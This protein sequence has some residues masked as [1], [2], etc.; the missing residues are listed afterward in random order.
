MLQEYSRRG[1]PG[2]HLSAEVIHVLTRAITTGQNSYRL[3]WDAP[4]GHWLLDN[5]MTEVDLTPR[6]ETPSKPHA[7]R[8]DKVSSRAYIVACESSMYAFKG[9]G[10]NTRQHFES[11]FR[12]VLFRFI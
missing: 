1:R 11:F 4:T 12:F 8:L 3:H 10:N 2:D 9:L 5:T 6:L 7:L